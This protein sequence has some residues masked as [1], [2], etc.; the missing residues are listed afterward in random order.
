VGTIEEEVL[1][2]RPDDESTTEEHRGYPDP[3]SRDLEAPAV[4]AAE[5]SVSANPVEEPPEVRRG[6]E[7][8]EWDALEQAIV[9][10]LEDDYD[11]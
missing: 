11:H 9:V 7:V 6:L 2:T 4:D 5:Q 8:G 1:M 10:D 3:D